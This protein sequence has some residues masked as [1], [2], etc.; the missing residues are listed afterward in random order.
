VKTRAT[1]F[2]GNGLLF[3]EDAAHGISP[4]EL[5]STVFAMAT[6]SSIVAQVRHPSDGNI[7]IVLAN[8]EAELDATEGVR[9]YFRGELLTPSRSVHVFTVE[10]VSIL[11]LP[12]TSERTLIR[13]WGN[14]EREPSWIG[15]LAVGL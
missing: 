9:E 8:D 15:V 3:I 6:D 7:T 2:A 13:I 11:N 12:V 4:D 14:A 5:D 10:M 1:L